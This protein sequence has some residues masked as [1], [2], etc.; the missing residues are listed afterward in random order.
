M[1][2]MNA[3]AQSIWRKVGEISIVRPQGQMFQKKKK[4][5]KN[6]KFY[7]NKMVRLLGNLKMSRLHLLY[8]R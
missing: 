3:K 5:S 7:W 6:G 8:D 2:W 1:A 4:G